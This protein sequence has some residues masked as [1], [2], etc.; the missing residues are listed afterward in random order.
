MNRI[1]KFLKDPSS[2]YV[3]F[4]LLSTAIFWVLFV[5]EI[6]AILF[7]GVLVFFNYFWV[8]VPISSLFKGI[9]FLCVLAS[10]AFFFVKFFQ[11]CLR[12]YRFSAFREVRGSALPIFFITFSVFYLL[13]MLFPLEFE[14]LEN[15]PGDG[16]E[17]EVQAYVQ[18]RKVSYILPF[19][20]FFSRKALDGL[21]NKL[22]TAL[23]RAP[24]CVIVSRA[25]GV[26]DTIKCSAQL[27]QSAGGSRPLF[28]E[29][30][31]ADNDLYLY[32]NKKN[33]AD[34][35][36]GEIL[37]RTKYEATFSGVKKDI[38]TIR[39]FGILIFDKE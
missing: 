14:S 10:F 28:L 4:L 19:P 6:P 33:Q 32:D 26:S 35:K 3:S 7:F 36:L 2:D 34:F 15:I 39:A 38:T 31:L 8:A 22:I 11:I 37:K 29:S 23:Y 27:A 12:R 24:D 21:G 5:F 17:G 16:G 20:A 9:S 1:R 13:I 25:G 18:R 30:G